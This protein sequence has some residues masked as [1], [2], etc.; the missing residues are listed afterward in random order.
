MAA[1]SGSAPIQQDNRREA[2]AT[3]RLTV[4][5]ETSAAVATSW[6]VNASRRLKTKISDGVDQTTQQSIE[7]PQDV[8]RLDVRAPASPKALLHPKAEGSNQP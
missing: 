3:A 8:A 4:A 2:Y 5:F 1:S 6:V 7:P